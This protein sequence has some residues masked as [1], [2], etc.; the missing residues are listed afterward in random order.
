MTNTT[1]RP[2]TPR[3]ASRH[4]ETGLILDKVELAERV[5]QY[6]IYAPRIAEKAQP[7][8]F[9]IIRL[10]E[11][12]ERIPLT[13]VDKQPTSGSIT[14]IVQTVGRSTEKLHQLG[15]GEQVLDVLG[16]L[17]NPSE[18]KNYGRVLVVGGGL[19]TALAYPVAKALKEAG[20]HVTVISGARNR[21]LMILE[22]EIKSVSDEVF[23]TTDDG[24]YGFHGFVTQ[25]LQLLLDAGYRFN[26]ALAVGP[27][28]MMHA[29]AEITRPYQISTIVSLNTIMVDGTGMCGGCRV[30]V[31]S[32]TRFTCVD[33]PEF[34]G[35]LVDFDTVIKRNRAYDHAENCRLD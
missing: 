33:G 10:S 35:H 17:G 32:E 12:G 34:D 29:V 11:A 22:D 14:L 30:R 9:V 4:P 18:I 2:A 31:G 3:P 5:T 13:I 19:G 15:E 26:H 23:F 21:A 16:P 1:P 7:G 28:Q 25:Q 24:S 8:Q 20:N 6:E 27:L